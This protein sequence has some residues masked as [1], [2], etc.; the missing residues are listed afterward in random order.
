[1]VLILVCKENA[2]L[3]PVP[4]FLIKQCFIFTRTNRGYY[5]IILFIIKLHAQSDIET[6]KFVSI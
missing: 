1:M 6:E 4:Y 3:H 2:K 5:L